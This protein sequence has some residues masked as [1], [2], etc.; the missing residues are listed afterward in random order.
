MQFPGDE[1]SMHVGAIAELEMAWRPAQP[2]GKAKRRL[3]EEAR[4]K[5]CLDQVGALGKK[6]FGFCSVRRNAFGRDTT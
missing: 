5:Q 6:E 4:G 3:G 2:G 1:P